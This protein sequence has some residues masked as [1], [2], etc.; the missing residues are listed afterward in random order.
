MVGYA[1]VHDDAV[2]QAG[3][4]AKGELDGTFEE[5]GIVLFEPF[6]EEGARDLDDE[7]AAVEFDGYYGFKPG[8]ENFL[9]FFAGEVVF[10]E[11]KTIVPYSLVVVLHILHVVFSIIVHNVHFFYSKLPAWGVADGCPHFWVSGDGVTFLP[12]SVSV[13]LRKSRL[14]DVH[15]AKMQQKYHPLR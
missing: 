9:V 15:N 7:C 13:S 5:F 1:F 8:A 12:C 11:F 6:V 2:L 10:D 3:L 4:V 14:S